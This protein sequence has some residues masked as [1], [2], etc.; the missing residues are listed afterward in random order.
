MRG[1][2]GGAVQFNKSG[3]PLES[4]WETAPLALKPPIQTI[5][6][7]GTVPKTDRR[8]H[9]VG[10]LDPILIL[11]VGSA[12]WG[13]P[14]FGSKSEVKKTEAILGFPCFKIRHN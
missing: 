12:F 7:S 13:E 9:H 1:G 6:R 3:V 5:L 10:L 14:L 11:L 4:T 2:W 8:D